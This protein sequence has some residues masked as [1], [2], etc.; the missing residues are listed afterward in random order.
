MHRFRLFNHRKVRSGSAKGGEAAQLAD[1]IVAVA[2]AAQA[3]IFP[4]QQECVDP[5]AACGLANVGDHL[6]AAVYGNGLVD[7]TRSPPKVRPAV[8]TVFNLSRTKGQCPQ[9][10]H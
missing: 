1:L 8:R 7:A 2:P 5:G 4:V 6:V 9:S 10:P 3:V